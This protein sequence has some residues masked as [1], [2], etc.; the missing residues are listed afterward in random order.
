VGQEIERKFLVVGNAWRDHVTGSERLVDGL[1]A[2]TSKGRKVRIRLYPDRATL[3]IKTRKKGR[4][5]LEFEYDIP[6]PDAQQLLDTECGR[7][8]LSKTRHYIPFADFLW[9]VDVYEPPLDG[10]IIAEVE[11]DSVDQDPPLPS[12]AG[13]EVTQ[14]PAFRKR[15]LFTERALRKF[16]SRPG[17]ETA[18]TAPAEP[19]PAGFEPPEFEPIELPDLRARAARR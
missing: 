5:R 9:E 8:I 16:R 7:T 2:T 19:A 11:L 6:V 4:S 14:D 1:L 15:N 3:T 13:R 12:W 17:R 18:E 10:V